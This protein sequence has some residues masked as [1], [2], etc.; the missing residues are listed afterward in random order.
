MKPVSLEA[1][2]ANLESSFLGW[3]DTETRAE[4]GSSYRRWLGHGHF[5]EVAVIAVLA[6]LTV[7]TLGNAGGRMENQDNNSKERKR[8][9][10]HG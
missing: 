6:G 10:F 9:G 4:G 2:Q 5:Q 1:T 7:A 3:R 8:N